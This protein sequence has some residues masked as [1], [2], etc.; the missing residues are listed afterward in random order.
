MSP[1][2]PRRTLMTRPILSLLSWSAALSSLLVPSA[3]AAQTLTLPAAALA[4]STTR[5]A[6]VARLATEAA[7]SYRDSNQLT[8]LDN[9]FRLQLLAGHSA[10]ARATLAQLRKAQLGGTRHPVP[11]PSTPSTRSI[12]VPGSSSPTPPQA[13]RTRSPVPS[14][15]GS[16]N[17]TIAPRHS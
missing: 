5:A 8:Q 2:N 12:S 4:D 15:N 16:P 1:S 11:A 9:M 13:S 7:A 3:I 17:W 14:A 10:E 6:A